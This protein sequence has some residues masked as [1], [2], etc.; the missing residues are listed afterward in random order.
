MRIEDQTN[1]E[2]IF[3][4]CELPIELTYNNLPVTIDKNEL[5]WFV[6]IKRDGEYPTYVH[7]HGAHIGTLL[8]TAYMNYQVTFSEEDKLKKLEQEREDRIKQ[9]EQEV[10]E[11][12]KEKEKNDS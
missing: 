4:Q 9:L 8:W 10:A 1:V 12:K 11:L 3:E 2:H 5:G 7:A 6:S